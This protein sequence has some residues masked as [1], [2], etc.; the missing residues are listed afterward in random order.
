MPYKN[1]DDKTAWN[2][3]PHV[4]EKH[5]ASMRKYYRANK[6]KISAYNQNYYQENKMATREAHR[7]NNLVR[8]ARMTECTGPKVFRIEYPDCGT[9]DYMTAPEFKRYEPDLTDARVEKKTSGK[10]VAVATQESLL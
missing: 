6:E 1:A 3:Q 8:R 9:Y 7:K 5:R 2:N 10:W 4:M